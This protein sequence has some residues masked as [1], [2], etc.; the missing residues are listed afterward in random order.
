MIQERR[1]LSQIIR[2]LLLDDNPDDILAIRELQ[3]EFNNLQ[4]EQLTN[5]RDYNQAL[6]AGNFE[7]VI[8]DYQLRS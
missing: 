4:V 8:T 6:A 1:I 7:L 3:R 2:I 5:A